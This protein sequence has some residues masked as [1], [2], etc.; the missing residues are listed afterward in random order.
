MRD[1]ANGNG[2]IKLADL[3]AAC[4]ELEFRFYPRAS[5]ESLRYQCGYAE[6]NDDGSKCF[7]L[8]V[9]AST[10]TGLSE[11]MDRWQGSAK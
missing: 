11:A 2:E 7:H 9:H 6:Y 1:S 3:R 8:C 5:I 4:P 10:P